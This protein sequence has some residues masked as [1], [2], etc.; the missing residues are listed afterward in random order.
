M[1]AL[2]LFFINILSC[3]K[4]HTTSILISSQVGIFMD[5]SKRLV[6]LKSQESFYAKLSQSALQ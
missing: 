5:N 4:T 6:H 3:R 1:L 2:K